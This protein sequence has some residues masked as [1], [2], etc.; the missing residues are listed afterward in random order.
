[1]KKVLLILFSFLVVAYGQPAWSSWIGV[2]SAALGYALF[3]VA[4]DALPNSLR[5]KASFLWFTL[6]QFV[7]LSWMATPDFQGYYII[8]VYLGLSAWLG[9]QFAIFTWL[10]YRSKQLDWTTLLGLAGLWTLF[11]WSRFLIFCGFAFN[12]VGLSL[13]C[14][15]YS[16]QLASVF[17]VFGMSFWVVFTNLSALKA[18]RSKEKKNIVLWLVI[19]VLPYIS[20]FFHLQ[21][22]KYEIRGQKKLATT[23]ILLVQTALLPSQKYPIKRH[24]FEFIPPLDQWD[25]IVTYIKEAP[26]RHPDLVVLPEACVPFGFDLCLYPFEQVKQKLIDQWGE[27][28]VDCFPTFGWPYAKIRD[29]LS[30]GKVYVSNAFLLQTLSSFLRSYVIAGLDFHDESVNENFNSAFFFSPHTEKV[31][32]YDKRILLP[33]SEYLPF[34]SLKFFT[35][36]YGINEFFT[37]GEEPKLFAGSFLIAPSICYEELFPHLMREAHQKGAQ[38]FVNLSNDAWYPHSMLPLQHFTHGLIRSV[39]NG[40]PLIR[41]CN[42]GITA[43]VDGNGAVLS[44]FGRRKKESQEMAGTLYF[45]LPLHQFKT[46]FSV[47]GNG[48]VVCVSLFCFGYSVIRKKWS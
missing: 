11:E 19:A 18:I 27:D 46:L 16:L 6:V 10:L 26:N 17:G 24:F 15:S 4:V 44:Q 8:G 42:T 47:W 30:K 29:D 7:Q 22:Q 21:Y 36:F 43:I 41:A 2:L 37:P 5:V 13:S 9:L 33:L 28:I 34:S 25:R 23:S 45:E 20:G 48:A 39:E 14:S 12:L 1:L 31:A 32:R 35:E 38:A 3:W 40:I